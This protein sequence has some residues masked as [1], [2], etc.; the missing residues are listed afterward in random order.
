MKVYA[1]EKIPIKS[2][3]KDVEYGALVQAKNLANL[4]FAFKHIALMPDCHQGYGMPIGGVFA[5]KDVVVPNAVGKDIG[6][7]M[8]AIKT[9]LQDISNADLI[10]IVSDIKKQ[11]PVGMKWHSSPQ[12]NNFIL[13]GEFGKIISEQED[14]IDCQIGTLGSGNHFIEIQK[15]T[16]DNSIWVMVHSGSRNLGSK[17]ADYYDKIATGL[18]EKYFST[19]DKKMKLA[20][21]PISTPEFKEYMRDMNICVNFALENRKHMVEKIKNIFFDITNCSF[22]NFINIPHNYAKIEN[23]YG[24]NVVVHRKGATSAKRGEFG[25]IPGSQ[26]SMSYIVQGLGSPESFKS[27]SHGAGRKMGRKQAQKE[28]NFSKEKKA[29]DD[30][31]IIHSINSIENLDEAPGAYKNISEVMNNQIDLVEIKIELKPIAVIK[32]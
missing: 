29:L 24:E 30:L 17:V 10:K 20:F 25:I 18:N 7:G 32:G 13:P 1:E 4:P 5:A 22:E 16:R 3:C 12:E 6:C 26:G 11:I 31:G 8:S 2:W 19:V 14:K 23:H 9:S 21:L 15:C 28:L 27:C